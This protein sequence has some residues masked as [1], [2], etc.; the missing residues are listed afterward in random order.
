MATLTITALTE[1]PNTVPRYAHD[2]DYCIFVGQIAGGPK[3][4][5]DRSYDL[6]LCPRDGSAN[7]RFSS[8]GPDYRSMELSDLD[9]LQGSLVWARARYMIKE[10]GKDVARLTRYAG[11]PRKGARGLAAL[12]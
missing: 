12:L 8:N 6:W 4:A 2:C 5:S 10:W 11:T 1:T 3:E 7:L 9:L